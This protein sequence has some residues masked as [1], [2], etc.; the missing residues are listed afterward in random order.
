MKSFRDYLKEDVVPTAI[1]QDGSIDL[2]RE[3][4]RAQI[5]SSLA[6]VLADPSVTPYNALMRASKVLSYFSI[7][8]PKRVYLDGEKGIEAIELRQF[9][10]R[11][12]MTDQ[13]EFVK[14]VP[15]KFYLF[16]QYWRTHPN[17]VPYA[18]TAN[19]IASTGGMFKVAAKVVDKVE[20]DRLIDMAE[21]SLSEGAE[22][23]QA[24]VKALAPKEDMHTAL[25]DC[26]CS[27][28]DSPSTKKAIK[29]SM[30]KIDEEEQID[31][32]SLKTKISA[33]SKR[34]KMN[35]YPG[36]SYDDDDDRGA[37]HGD[38]MQS[39]TM[40]HIKKRHGEKGAAAAEKA[41]S[42]EKKH[43]PAGIMSDPTSN[44]ARW[45][46]K[47]KKS[48]PN[49]G[50]LDKRDQESLKS[51]HKS[52]LYAIKKAPKPHLPEETMEEAMSRKQK[53]MAVRR[54]MSHDPEA[55]ERILKM[56]KKE[57]DEKKSFASAEKEANKWQKHRL[58]EEEQIDEG[59][60]PAS[61][62]KH[63]QKL[64]SMSPDEL[65]Q[66][67][68]GKS[69]EHLKSMA[70]RHGY[71]KDS[72][73]YSKHGSEKKLDE[74]SLGKLVRYK[75]ERDKDVRVTGISASHSEDMAKGHKASGNEKKSKEF[76]D[77]AKW[78]RGK[79]KKMK[80]GIRLAD[81]KM[82]GK[83][84]INAPLPKHPYMEETVDE[85]MGSVKKLYAMKKMKKKVST[86]VKQG[87]GIGKERTNTVL[88]TNKGDPSAAG[89]GGVHRIPRDKYDPT[90]HNLASE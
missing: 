37:K 71:G 67:F 66:K 65:K 21:V 35:K 25:G 77:E 7:I 54:F 53:D 45:E 49:K 48:G 41:G 80:A 75:N 50:K 6:S 16:I 56:S 33:Y 68:A 2:E 42:H 40:A 19:F 69:E 84:R 43:Y 61:V 62:I 9:G 47:T 52:K 81:K 29:V 82:K 74:V 8:L 90:K 17:V 51:I 32:V 58:K 27:Q 28:G 23:R 5:N 55:G 85:A 73:V 34:A 1:V 3:V 14:E 11:M 72:D 86:Q 83:A 38:K 64:A 76:S 4:V 63:K 57:R 79:Q 12:G 70:R 15:G 13:G 88:V 89:G 78:L 24:L 59:G 87:L 30:K 36:A 46:L 60:M 20:L 10:D 44:K 39:K 31:E 18:A 22:D 26:D